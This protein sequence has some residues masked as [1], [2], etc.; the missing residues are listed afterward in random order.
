MYWDRKRR[1]R[2][3][4]FGAF[5]QR[6]DRVFT[7]LTAVSAKLEENETAEAREANELHTLPGIADEEPAE[8]QSIM[9]VS[10][11]PQPRERAWS[12]PICCF[13]ATLLSLMVGITIS[14]PSNVT[15]DLSENTIGLSQDHLLST[16]LQS[17]YAVSLIGCY[18]ET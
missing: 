10:A 11:P 12:V 9:V 8:I 1:V 18:T 3:L 16:F 7:M 4:T 6:P 15:L 14:F 2:Q 17:A 5:M 13:V